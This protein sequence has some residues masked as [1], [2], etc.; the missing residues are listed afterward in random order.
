MTIPLEQLLAAVALLLLLSVFASRAS[1]RFGVPALVLF[2]AVGMFAGSE[3]FGGIFFNDAAAAQRVGII[4]LAFILFSAGLETNWK[5]V[6]DSFW[7][8]SS[9]ATVGVLLTTLLVGV[10]AHLVLQFDL[11]VGLLLGAIVSSTDAAAVFSILR[12]RGVHL[13]EEIAAT[14]ELESGSN[15]PMAVFLTA[16]FIAAIMRPGTGIAG[17]LL[18][19]AQ[20]M[21]F[22]AVCGIVIGWVAVRLLNRFSLQEDGLYPVVSIAV[23]LATY[24]GTVSIGGSGFLAVYAAGIVMGNRNFI[25]RRT[26][27]RFHGGLAWLA[28]IAMFLVLGLLVYPSQLA[29]ITLMG[30]SVAFF[31]MFIARPVAVFASL[32]GS[33]FTIR[34]KTVVS[35]V[36]LRGAVPIVLATFP[37]LARTPNSN[38]IF[39]VVFFS[40]LASLLIQGTSIPFVARFMAVE[41]PEAREPSS[42]RVN[43]ATR[44]EGAIITVAV[45]ERSP[46]ARRRL[47]DLG[48]WPREALILVLYRGDECFVP[49]GSTRL[50]PG[51]R[52]IVLTSRQSVDL[53]RDLVGA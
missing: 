5:F 22:G 1:G 45:S 10:F 36:G 27:T 8:A 40:V 16:A 21:I 26:L 2:L 44:G 28:Q 33:D 51:D 7:R 46:V 37:L 41:A 13:R 12:A 32:M 43:L 20:E 24:S 42:R 11:E 23:V 52:L 14:L 53:L 18:D 9:L 29:E 50:L 39:N 47:V 30:G 35:W 31:L 6:Q 38:M 49:T 34:E 17:F 19:F 48:R 4:A 25:Q 3:G 15:D